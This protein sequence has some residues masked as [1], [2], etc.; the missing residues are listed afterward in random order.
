MFDDTKNEDVN[1]YI[2]KSISDGQ[3]PYYDYNKFKNRE[4]IGSGS[5]GSVVRATWE[6]GRIFALK[7]FFNND[8]ITFKKLIKEV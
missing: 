2:E 7:S 5:F 6:D 4:L 3:I 1:N 8:K